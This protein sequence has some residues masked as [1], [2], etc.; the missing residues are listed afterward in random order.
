MLQY[1]KKQKNDKKQPRKD[2]DQTKEEKSSSRNHCNANKSALLYNIVE[3][4]EMET[5]S[6]QLN[7][8]V[9][10]LNWHHSLPPEGV[11]SSCV[12]K[13]GGSIGNGSPLRGNDL[14]DPKRNKIHQCNCSLAWTHCIVQLCGRLIVNDLGTISLQ[15]KNGNEWRLS[16]QLNLLAVLFCRPTL[17]L[18]LDFSYFRLIFWPYL[19][20]FLFFP[21]Q[22]SINIIPIAFSLTGW[23][24]WTCRNI[25]QLVLSLRD[26]ISYHFCYKETTYILCGNIFHC[27]I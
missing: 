6:S 7:G 4:L 23:F 16:D 5:K 2:K 11:R 20:S 10:P 22:P 15:E 24:S 17:L 12:C 19:L 18:C 25:S 13:S 14:L 21:P 27:F 9:L 26:M 3:N 8:S 1:Y